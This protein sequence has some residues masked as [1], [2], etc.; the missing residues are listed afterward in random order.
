M[1]DY[2]FALCE[3]V[4]Q[5]SLLGNTEHVDYK[6]RDQRKQAWE[7][8]DRELKLQ[9]KVGTYVINIILEYSPSLSLSI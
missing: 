9:H 3:V 5:M 2:K 6:D 4:Q 7:K 1:D 8:I